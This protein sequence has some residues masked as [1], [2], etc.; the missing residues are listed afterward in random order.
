M[1]YDTDKLVEATKRIRTLLRAIQ[2]MRG[3]RRKDDT[4][5]EDHWHKRFPEL[6]AQLLDE[7]YKFKGWNKDAIPTKET[8][9]ELGL[10]Y[11]YKSFIEKGIFTDK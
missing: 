1:N 10:D 9:H 7:Y 11:V 4:P 2:V 6:E 3:V 5:P 8:L